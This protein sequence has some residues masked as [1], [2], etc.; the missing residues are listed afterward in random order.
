MEVTRTSLVSGKLRTRDLPITKEEIELYN[1]GAYIQ[2]AFK[3]CN[4]EQREFYMTGI[5]GDE[6][7]IL[8]DDED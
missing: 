1:N 7:N 3:S 5:T 2:D 4:A 8:A 6:W